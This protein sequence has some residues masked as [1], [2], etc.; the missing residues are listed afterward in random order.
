[1]SVKVLVIDD[2]PYIRR[3]IVRMLERA[4]YAA[5]EASNGVQG[6]EILKAEQ[7]DVVT[8]DV[9]M[10]YMD[11]HEFLAEAR[12]DASV[13]HIPIIIITAIGKSEQSPELSPHVQAEAYLSKPF[14][15][16]RLVETIERQL[17][18]R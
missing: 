2:A 16:S 9:S 10:P 18:R 8:C 13:K 6:L 7:P 11:G 5:I 14:S 17:N 4:G 15:S 12:R 1:M 3:L